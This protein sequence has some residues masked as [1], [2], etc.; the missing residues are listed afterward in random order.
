[1]Q[2]LKSLI[3]GHFA[4]FPRPCGAFCSLQVLGA[5]CRMHFPPPALRRFYPGGGGGGQQVCLQ[6]DTGTFQ[7]TKQNVERKSRERHQPCARSGTEAALRPSPALC[8]PRKPR[9][10]E[11]AQWVLPRHPRG[12]PS[13]PAEPSPLCSP[14]DGAGSLQPAPGS[15]PHPW[16][17]SAGAGPFF[18]SLEPPRRHRE[19][20]A[21]ISQHRQTRHSAIASA[22]ETLNSNISR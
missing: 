13:L 8:R 10:A 11:P 20:A 7:V 17:G 14:G 18:Q 5:S 2:L 21:S 19:A 22:S 15:A 4:A 12:R 16:Q 9:R 3:M 6:G 1:M